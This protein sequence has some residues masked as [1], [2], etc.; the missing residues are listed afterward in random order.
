MF[1]AWLAGNQSNNVPAAQPFF[2]QGQSLLWQV[3]AR[4]DNQTYTLFGCPDG[5]TGAKAAKQTAISYTSTHTLVQLQA[6]NA[7]ITLDFFSPVSLTDYTRQSIPLSYLTVSSDG[8]A[9]DIFSA[10]DDSWTAQQGNVQ[11]GLQKAGDALLFTL[12][13]TNSVT[14]SEKQQ[15]ATWGHF[16][17]ATS[18]H[19]GAA[20]YQIGAADDVHATFASAGAL[21]GQ[22]AAYKTGYLVAL[23]DK[24]DASSKSTTFAI[25]LHQAHAIN[26]LGDSYAGYFE[27]QYGTAAA[28]TEHFLADYPA[29]LTESS[30]LDKRI[31][32]IGSAVSSQYSD[33]LEAH[34]RQMYVH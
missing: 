14:F 3:L 33:I 6:G 10:V 2:W 18:A 28:V 34:V 20:T 24:L 13:G 5:V 7:A 29:A 23:A 22:Q 16:I 21:S 27:A 11:A 30:T 4:V 17:F 19:N 32:S 26:F 12:N 25:G 1:L 31:V 9:V 8:S 15:M